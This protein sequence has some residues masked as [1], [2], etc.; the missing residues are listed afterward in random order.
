M[1]DSVSYSLPDISF[2][3]LTDGV[4]MMNVVDLEYPSIDPDSAAV[5]VSSLVTSVNSTSG[6]FVLVPLGKINPG[7]EIIIPISDHL[8]PSSGGLKEI[9]LQSDPN[10]LPV[11]NPAPDEWITA[12]INNR[13]PAPI[14]SVGL[15][16]TPI[17]F[18]NIQYPFE[19]GGTGFNWGDPTI[20]AKP[21]T[22]TLAVEKT[23][24]PNVQNDSN[25]CPIIDAYTLNNDSWTNNGLG[26]IS[27]ESAG[28]SKC[29]IKIQTQHFS[30]FV[31]SLRHIKSIQSY[32]PGT[33]GLGI[34]RSDA[35]LN[36]LVIPDEP[37]NI[38]DSLIES[39]HVETEHRSVANPP[40]GFANVLCSR[41]FGYGLLV[42]EYTNGN[43]PHRVIFLKM[44]L[45]DGAG[46]IL[47]TGNGAIYDID[48]YHTKIFN[49][50]ARHRADFDSCSIQITKAI[51]K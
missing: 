14:T 17:I 18:L 33:F 25:G 7:Q 8:I 13:I 41:E 30:K 46:N 26:E 16:G 2:P 39:F 45:L 15:E 37:K 36:L 40:H 3:P 9:T 24:L 23:N 31:F 32:G 28:L 22:L 49:A 34:V 48:A 38:H 11:G 1:T 27:S 4:A 5:A 29:H 35:N 47:G 42:G 12:E 10:A 20:F 51:A 43:V 19:Y 6:Q 50:I 21:P 44:M